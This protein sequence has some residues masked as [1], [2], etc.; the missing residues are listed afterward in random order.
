MMNEYNIHEN[1]NRLSPFSIIYQFIRHLPGIGI[2]LYFAING[3]GENL[4]YLIIAIIFGLF[5]FPITLLNYYYFKYL[6]TD[7]EFIIHSGILSKKQRVIP[8]SKIQNINLSQ[9]FLQRILGIS[10]IQ[11]E[12]AGD[13]SSEGILDSL[14]TSKAFE[15]KTIIKEYQD[16]IVS[17]KKTEKTEEVSEL[18]SSEENH[19]NSEDSNSEKELIQMSLKELLIFGLL[20]FRPVLIVV[21]AWFFGVGQQFAPDFINNYI[22]DI[23]FNA[24]TYIEQI[25]IMEIVLYS[26]VLLIIILIISWGLDILLTVNQWWNFKLSIGKN[27]LFTSHGLLNRKQGTIPMKK[28]QMIVLFSNYFRDKFGY[29]GLMLETAGLGAVENRRPE[30]A[31]PFAK[32]D[33]IKNLI[34]EFV[35]FDYPFNFN[36]VSK[37]TIRRAFVRYLLLL[38]ILYLILYIIEFQFFWFLI[39]LPLLY[40]AAVLRWQHRGWELQNEKIIIKQGFFFKKIKI[41]PLNKIQTLNVRRTFFQRRLKLATFHIDTAA[42]SGINDASIIDIDELDALKLLDLISTEIINRK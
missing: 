23:V 17:L 21:V 33:I 22:E 27:K 3:S 7:K 13:I 2:T 29:W 26:I 10:K 20:R 35:K 36:L 24:E 14:K 11:I 30:T 19:L 25:N 15:I 38:L 9:N 1:G 12:T 16:D 6:I 32:F 39:L 4:I 31:I 28:L 34:S 41:V 8:L 37:K 5:I 40:Y 18:I 42:S